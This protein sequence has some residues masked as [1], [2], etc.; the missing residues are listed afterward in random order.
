M[1]PEQVAEGEEVSD[2]ADVYAVGVVLY[3]LVAGVLPVV[4]DSARDLM[5]RKLV[6]EAPPL[7]AV[8]PDAPPALVAL[9]QRCL[10]RDPSA[11]P[12]AAALETSLR[13]IAD[14]AGAP[15]LEAVPLHDPVDRAAT[16]AARVRR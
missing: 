8:V 16:V 15:S 7:S 5:L 12:S 10:A 1:A 11:R 3:Q 4:A 14:Q 2:R 9:L 6:D 13:A